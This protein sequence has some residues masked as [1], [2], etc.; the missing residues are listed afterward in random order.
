MQLLQY[1]LKYL[2]NCKIPRLLENENFEKTAKS[3]YQVAD[4]YILTDLKNEC[5]QLLN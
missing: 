4:K 1:F 2:Y 3:L 5:D